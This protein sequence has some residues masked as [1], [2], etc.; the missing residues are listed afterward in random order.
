MNVQTEIDE[1]IATISPALPKGV[2]TRL[3]EFRLSR[4]KQ[5]GVPPLEDWVSSAPGMSGVGSTARQFSSTFLTSSR[6]KKLIIQP[7]T[8]RAAITIRFAAPPLSRAGRAVATL[9]VLVLGVW[10]CWGIVKFA[11]EMLSLANRWWPA[12]ACVLAV[13]WIIYREPAWPGFM[14][15]LLSAG[16]GLGRLIQVYTRLDLNSLAVDQPTVQYGAGH[17]VSVSSSTQIVGS[18]NESSTIT[19]YES[20]KGVGPGP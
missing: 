14:L 15:L 8:T 16:A 3:N 7:Q 9:V 20:E 13:G 4:R 17:G 6:W 18:V 12:I 19:H 10:G 2:G 1:L 5:Y 11:D